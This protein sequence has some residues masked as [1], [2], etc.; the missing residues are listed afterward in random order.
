MTL[1]ERMAEFTAAQSPALREA[2]RPYLRRLRTYLDFEAEVD[3]AGR[4]GPYWAVI[5]AA[6]YTAAHDRRRPAPLRQRQLRGILWAQTCIFLALRLQDDVYDGQAANRNGI[7]AATLFYS[8]AAA[9]FRTLFESRAPFWRNYEM[10]I[11]ASCESIARIADAGRNF[12]SSPSRLPRLY[13]GTNSALRIGVQAACELSGRPRLASPLAE[14]CDALAVAW[15]MI[16]DLEDMLEDLERGMLN[17]AARTIL[18]PLSRSNAGTAGLAD[19]LILRILTGNPHEKVLDT[20][21]SYFARAEGIAV[22]CSLSTAA[23][24]ISKTLEALEL[25]KKAF[26]RERVR[27]LFGDKI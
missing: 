1:L 11:V 26:H 12:R 3:S 9:T 16:D 24:H 25:R 5:P 8:E 18:G 21:A 2:I 4:L 6:V 23:A 15:Q 14:C 20:A 17:Y 7:F 13:A 22:D 10:L 27:R 19:E